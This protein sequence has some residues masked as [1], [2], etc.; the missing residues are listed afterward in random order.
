MT[1]N[2]FQTYFIIR[3]I[4]TCLSIRLLID[5]EYIYGIQEK[6]YEAGLDRVSVF[7]KRQET[8]KYHVFFLILW[9]SSQRFSFTRSALHAQYISNNCANSRKL[10]DSRWLP[11]TFGRARVMTGR[12]CERR[13]SMQ[14][15]VA[16]NGR[17]RRPVLAELTVIPRGCRAEL[18]TTGGT[19]F[20]ETDKSESPSHRC[21]PRPVPGS[22]GRA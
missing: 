17:G 12:R 16:L 7:I 2:M 22:L 20:K 21:E 18:S 11:M 10:G 9:K 14:R 13:P 4:N 15:S 3:R 8:I 1:N 6:N 5:H 19:S